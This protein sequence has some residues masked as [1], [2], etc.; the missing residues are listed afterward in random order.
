MELAASI[1]AALALLVASIEGA[2]ALLGDCGGD[3]VE[4]VDAEPF[5]LA[6]G[7]ARD[8]AGALAA[9]AGALDIA[10][11][12]GGVA[13]VGGGTKP[14]GEAAADLALGA[15]FGTDVRRPLVGRTLGSGS[16]CSD[17][18]PRSLAATSFPL[19]EGVSRTPSRLG[20]CPGAATEGIP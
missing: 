5:D 15:A 11:E 9:D 6:A 16:H 3:E 4:R 7:G 17:E 18:R 10:G 14:R 8:T 20:S 19:T 12:Q 2:L 1:E 13:R